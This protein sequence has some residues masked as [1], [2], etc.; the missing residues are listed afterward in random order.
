MDFGLYQQQSMKLLMTNELRQ[1]ITM[2]QYST[3]E[4]NNYLKEQQLENPLIE[5]KEIEFREE[6]E[7]TN[8]NITTPFYDSKNSANDEEDDDFSPID[9]INKHEEG[10]Q[11]V[12]LKQIR[13]LDIDDKLNRVVTFLALSVDEN[14]YITIPLEEIAHHLGKPLQMIEEG[15]RILQSLEPDGVGARSLK[16]CLLIQLRKLKPRDLLAERIVEKHLQTLG[17][18]QFHKIAKEENI[19]L[20]EVQGIFDFIQSLN[21]KPGAIYQQ[22]PTTYITPD[23]TV[24]KINGEYFV[25]LNDQY[26]P[27]L[28]INRQYEALIQNGNKEVSQYMQKKYEH[29]LWIKKS[30]QQR[31]ETLYKVT[32][33]IVDAQR[34]FF[35]Y[36]PTHLKPLTLK[37]IAT[38]LNIHESTVSRVTT[39]KYVQTP[40]GLFELKYFFTSAVGVNSVTGAN[41]SEKV[42][43][44]LK[45]IVDEEDKK[46]PLS[47]QKIA[48]VM[49]E[50]YQI[51]VSRRTIAKYRDEMN[52]PSST[53]RKRFV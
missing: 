6:I 17:N 30:I 45:E 22:E 51:N 11:D 14:G 43:A 39:K 36:G 15:L 38:K 35:E 49:K 9:H 46:K 47:D 7:R 33:A 25:F 41:S 32:S 26:L 4:L 8:V 40:R 34:S 48:N 23:V 31:Q 24:K 18:K 2:L 37:M 16:E 42:K 10:L 19:S 1:A 5:L 29:F 50:K 28:T 3:I 27:K 44:I 12:L 20:E 21:P 53:Q 13:F 52:I